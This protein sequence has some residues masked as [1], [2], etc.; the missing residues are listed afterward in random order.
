[1]KTKQIIFISMLLIS[2]MFAQNISAQNIENTPYIEVVGRA[3]KDILPDEIYLSIS[4]NESDYGKESSLTAKEKQVIK[5]LEN[6]GIDIKEQ[7][8]VKDLGSNFKKY[9]L[10]KNEVILSKEYEL[11]TSSAKQAAQVMIALESIGVSKVM[12][13]NSKSGTA[14]ASADSLLL[15]AALNMGTAL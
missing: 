9:I 13:S 7:L 10:R 6:L 11:K 5:S 3:E 8:R 4:I 1:M 2:S 15:R 12:V 14:A